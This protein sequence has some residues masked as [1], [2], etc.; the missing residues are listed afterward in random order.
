MVNKVDIE[1]WWGR[2]G[3]SILLDVRTPAEYEQGHIPGARNLPLFT[4]QE[5]AIVGTL[6]KKEGPEAAL[7]KGLEIVGPKMR[8]F[9]EQ[10]AGLA[11]DRK[12]TI[13]C[14]RGG[15]RS[16]SMGWLLDLAGFEVETLIG[17]YKAF[18]RFVLDG[19][20]RKKLKLIVLGGKTGA[21]KTLILH[22][23]KARG[24]Q[25]IDL[26]GLAHHKGS[27]F[28]WIG[29]EAQPTSEQ[30][31]NKLFEA[32]D[33]LDAHKA[34]WIE[35]ESRTV[36][37][38]YIPQGMWEQMKAAPLLNIEL[39]PEERIRHL[40]DTYTQTDSEDLKN[41]FRNM[42][43]RLGGQHVNA[44]LEALDQNDYSSAVKI[45]LAYYDKT[46][47]YQLENTVAP[48][49]HRLSFDHLDPASIAEALIRFRIGGLMD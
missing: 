25:I 44:A 9:V 48:E 15:N 33:K 12:L 34:C 38:V 46:Y 8:S 43:K 45:A 6:Y 3:S 36:G 23:L 49:V 30:F 27:A 19:F 17:G 37:K 7:L 14:W 47:Q 39:P 1:N 18:R 26:E 42:K 40:V 28:G 29:E 21:G 11:P 35:N 32:F 5:R 22:E 2:G 13:H 4:N 24:E 20:F 10:A 16:G 31:E 41:C